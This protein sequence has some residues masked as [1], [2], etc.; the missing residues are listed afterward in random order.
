M[1]WWVFNSYSETLDCSF[2]SLNEELLSIVLGV[3]VADASFHFIEPPS[4]KALFSRAGLVSKERISIEK[5]I[6]NASENIKLFSCFE[7]V[8]ETITPFHY[9]LFCANSRGVDSWKG[10]WEEDTGLNVKLELNSLDWALQICR[11]RLT[12]EKGL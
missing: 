7:N 5:M 3:E 4:L 1:L 10:Q 6:E 9:A 2:D 8:C 12:L 11:E